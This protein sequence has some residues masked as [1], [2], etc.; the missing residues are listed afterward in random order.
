MKAKLTQTSTQVRNL[1]KNRRLATLRV[2]AAS[3]LASMGATTAF[4]TILTTGTSNISLVTATAVNSGNTRITAEGDALGTF[5]NFGVLDFNTGSLNVPDY[6]T[7][8]SIIGN[9]F[10][11][12][13][14]DRSPLN[15]FAKDGQ[16]DFYLATGSNGTSSLANYRFLGFSNTGGVGA[17]LGSLISL[18]NVQYVAGTTPGRVDTVTL[19]FS[20][21]GASAL[22]Y[23][24]GQVTSGGNV[25]IIAAPHTGTVASHWQGAVAST[26]PVLSSPSL[27]FDLNTSAAPATDAT[28]LL[29]PGGVKTL[30]SPFVIDRIMNFG[31]TNVSVVVANSG[32]QV[33]TFSFIPTGS[34]TGNGG[35]N[36]L[37]GGAT[38]A[39]N[40]TLSASGFLPG[41]VSSASPGTASIAIHNRSNPGDP[42]NATVNFQVNSV[43]TSRFIDNIGGNAGIDLGRQL[44]G[45]TNVTAVTLDTENTGVPNLG[46]NSLSIVTLLGTT[47]VS[48]SNAKI[49]TRGTLAIAAGAGDVTFSS[50]LESTSRN[51]SFTPLVGGNYV[52]NN[53][54]LGFVNLPVSYGPGE[55]AIGAGTNT[56][57]AGRIT[58]TGTFYEKALVT[59]SGSSVGTLTLANAAATVNTGGVSGS[60]AANIGLRADAQITATP[61]LIAQNGYSLIGL[62]NG[63]VIAAGSNVTGT[64]AF[65]TS[66]KLNGKYFGTVSVS[67]QHADQT[68]IGTALNDLPTKTFNL[69]T[70]VSGNSGNGSANILP[71]QSYGSIASPYFINRGSGFNSTVSFLGG[72]A[73]AN[74]TLAVAFGTSS[75][76][77]ASGD[78][79]A[80]TGNGIDKYVVQFSYNPSLTG[81]ATALGFY[82]GTKYVNPVGG[83]NSNEVSGAYNNSLTLGNYG[84]DTTN[85][86][87][88][89]VV[90]HP[91][92]FVPYVR[93]AGDTNFRGLVDIN[94]IR[95]IVRRGFYNDGLTTHLWSDGDFTGDGKV[96]IGDIRAIVREGKYNAGSYDLVSPS[97]ATP[98][99]TSRTASPATT[100][101]G[102][103][104]DGTNL[105]FVYDP[106]N[107]D[108]TVKY[109]GVIGNVQEL[110]LASTG[111]S[112]VL[113][114]VIGFNGGFDNKAP[115]DLDTIIT[116]GNFADGLDLGHILAPNLPT[117]TLLRDLTLSYS[118]QG[119]NLPD[120]NSNLIVGVPEPTTLSLLGLGAVGLL[121]RRKRKTQA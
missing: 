63:T 99:L 73:S 27:S 98:S 8:N 119:L 33:G 69:T 65:D 25:R 11:I 108:V 39:V 2:A 100:T 113:G 114:S 79:A 20:S 41:T 106:S 48:G 16:V 56:A 85:H 31:S 24:N 44:V 102:S 19:D 72:T 80:I 29:N 36:P 120:G 54:T 93:A 42:T 6:T 52:A 43:V 5:A 49:S 103:I 10:S 14:V 51:V 60:S 3:V 86:V 71:G 110:H 82:D 18:G 50:G 105:H 12:S 76:V 118:V 34:V 47:S 89:A 70:N 87:V 92:T 81:N 7:V 88:W 67:M 35:T 57:T 107:G 74:T 1:Q 104:G 77:R 46:S 21:G 101:L 15:S 91:G 38:T 66:G 55:T 23:L 96:D 117:A 45:S 78:K 30:P 116:S 37:A 4:A 59:A 64:A 9:T 75:S 84:I 111:T 83:T 40:L 61:T 95:Q 22:N 58:A 90:D 53:L 68:I 112:F 115:N 28:F 94:D 13:L 26:N 97:V 17:Q 62:D 32:T 109:D 121:A